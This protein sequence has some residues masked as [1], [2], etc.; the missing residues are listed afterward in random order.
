MSQL[1]QYQVVRDLH[2]AVING[3][4]ADDVPRPIGGNYLVHRLRDE[5]LG[6]GDHLV[7]AILLVS[8]R[9][10]DKMDVIASA[11]LLAL[12]P[13]VERR[14]KLLLNLPGGGDGARRVLIDRNRVE[15]LRV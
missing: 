2:A 8:Q 10:L 11:E 14:D 3:S 4:A 12:R 5:R 6:R 13:R 9:A 15:I 1:H 7:L